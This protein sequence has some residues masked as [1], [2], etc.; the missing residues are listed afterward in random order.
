ML[1][2]PNISKTAA[3]S[4]LAI[5]TVLWFQ[6]ALS[7]AC[8]GNGR[9]CNGTLY[10]ADAMQQFQQ[11]MQIIEAITGA[12]SSSRG[13]S[14][15][16][17]YNDSAIQTRV[18]CPS[19]F[20]SLYHLTNALPYNVREEIGSALKWSVARIHATEGIAQSISSVKGNIRYLQEGLRIGDTTDPTA[21]RQTIR[22]YEGM[23]EI[24]ECHQYGPSTSQQASQQANSHTSSSSYQQSSSA[25]QAS[26]TH[27]TQ[28]KKLAECVQQNFSNYRDGKFALANTCNHL[29]NIKYMFSVSAPFS[30]TYT[31]LK[32]KEHTLQR[33]NEDERVI[34]S[35]CPFPKVPQTLQG[36][37]I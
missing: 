3:T 13:A 37:C 22:I 19:D 8:D 29:I 30:G 7:G 4:I 34:F 32:P 31:T 23:L 1:L 18:D 27:Q 26:S 20:S 6:P 24:L 10:K 35:Y 28:N 33:G 12:M 14:S 21:T 25:Q 9:P 17:E 2:R 11:S 5:A 16:Q 36:G 15:A